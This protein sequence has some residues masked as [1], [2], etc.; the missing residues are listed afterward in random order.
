MTA[1]STICL[2]YFKNLL[3]DDGSARRS[4]YLS[5]LLKLG[6]SADHGNSCASVQQGVGLFYHPAYW[7]SRG[8]LVMLT[9]SSAS[10]LK[11]DSS[12]RRSLA[13][14]LPWKCQTRSW[15]SLKLPAREGISFLTRQTREGENQALSMSY[16]LPP[17]RFSFPSQLISKI[18]LF[19]GILLLHQKTGS[20]A[21]NSVSR[22]QSS[23]IGTTITWLITFSMTTVLPAHDGYGRYL[24]PWRSQGGFKKKGVVFILKRFVC[25]SVRYFRLVS[26]LGRLVLPAWY[27]RQYLGISYVLLATVALL[28]GF[29]SAVVNSRK[30]PCRWV[31]SCCITASGKGCSECS[32]SPSLLSG[33]L[34]PLHQVSSGQGNQVHNSAVHFV[35][36]VSN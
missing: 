25:H 33:P 29:C 23:P 17:T 24:L 22:L 26:E 20:Q 5:I 8:V 19:N 1:K 12:S 2:I 15:M 11:L 31:H 21:K 14:F 34:Q 6:S 3:S 28:L 16:S 30:L 13:A 35:K 18:T 7:Q 10:V 27:L 36:S 32:G 4:W 9:G